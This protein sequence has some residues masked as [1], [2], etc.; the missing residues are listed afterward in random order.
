MPL[1]DVLAQ[2]AGA[3]PIDIMNIDVEGLDREILES[4]DYDRWR[5]KLLI[6]EILGCHNVADVMRA[7]RHGFLQSRNYALFSKLDFSCFFIENR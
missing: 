4:L 5:P 2:Y 3:A 6:V 1:N 7:P